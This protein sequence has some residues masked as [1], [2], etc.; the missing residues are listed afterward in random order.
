MRQVAFLLTSIADLPPCPWTPSSHRGS[1]HP[2]L[3]GWF[4][5]RSSSPLTFSRSV[6]PLERLI[7][8]PI[9]QDESGDLIGPKRAS[10]NSKKDRRKMKPK[11][12]W[13]GEE[14]LLRME[15]ADKG[16]AEFLMWVQGQGEQED[17]AGRA[18]K[19][20]KRQRRIA[21]SSEEEEAVSD[22][23]NAGRRGMAGRRRKK[24]RREDVLHALYGTAVSGLSFYTVHGYISP[25]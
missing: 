7:T 1:P 3:L 19:A 9:A 21:A 13:K 6:S 4:H 25:G 8:P 20:R 23:D 16:Q 12:A 2:E 17:N 24:A 15:E 10:K 22:A 14:V 5:N 18:R 11:G